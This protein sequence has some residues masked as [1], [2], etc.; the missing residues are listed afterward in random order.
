[1]EDRHKSKTQL[2]DELRH[3]RRQL[4]ERT[5]LGEPPDTRGHTYWDAQARYEA[6]VKAF[7]GLVYIC[8]RSY[9]IEYTNDRMIRRT[10]RNPTGEKCYRALHDSDQICSW[11]QNERVFQGETVRWE[12]LSPK[13]NHWYY[14]VNTPIR[15]SDGTVSKMGVILDITERKNAEEMLKHNEKMLEHILSS[16]PLGISYFQDNALKWANQAMADMFGY[17]DG[18]DYIGKKQIEF[19]ASEEEF[20]EIRKHISQGLKEGKPA[21]CEAMFKRADGSV[22]FGHMRM[23]RTDLP[24][25]AGGIICTILDVTENRLTHEAL[26]QASEELE[27]RVVE[28]TA[29]LAATNERLLR[30]IT[31]RERVEQELREAEAKYRSLVEKVPAITYVAALDEQSSTLYVSPQ[32]QDYLGVSPGDYRA[33]PDIWRKRI[34]PDDRDRVL[35]ALAQ[36][37]ATEDPFVCEYRMITVEDRVVWFHD[38]AVHVYDA[39]GSPMFLQGFMLDITDQKEAEKELRRSE[40]RFRTVIESARDFIFIKTTDLRYTNVNPA[41]T[42]LLGLPASQILGRRAEDLYGDD[43]GAHIN[44]VDRRVLGGDSIEEEHTRLCRGVSRTFHDIRVPLRSSEG[45]VTGICG[46]SRDITERRKSPPVS[47]IT[48]DDYPSHAMRATLERAQ[49][50]CA[51]DG[52]VL[53]LGESGTGKD[54]LAR[55]IHEH[56]ARANGPFFAINCA[57]LAQDLAES[58]LFGHEPGAFTGA[59]GRKR[60]LLEL[61]EGGTLLLNE[62]GELSPL[63]QSKLLTFLDSRS[64]LRVGGEKSVT[65]NARL[66]A[67][68]HRDLDAEVAQGKFL[69]PLFY[70]LNVFTIRVPPLRERTDDIPLLVEQLVSELAID[71]QLGTV[72]SV[73][74][75]SVNALSRYGWPGNVRELRNVLERA[76]MLNPDGRVDLAGSGRFT[77]SSGWSYTVHFP[78]DRTLHEVTR[79]TTQM[80]CAEAL[81]RS[82]GNRRE[83][84]R[85]LG[86]SRDSLYRYLKGGARTR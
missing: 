62:I 70:R 76:L 8:S 52:I 39:D 74:T 21:Q 24:D 36:S 32:V 86:I 38:E 15:R 7:E 13:D 85:L 23:S 12:V 34:H 46:I 25:G 4:A 6:I 49:H 20:R 5:P 35:A 17:D 47:R 22:F 67:A 43:A 60:G 55:W 44:K 3:L 61:A 33:D 19:F 18:S 72:P 77:H 50:A 10:G 37:H 80:L 51:T 69:Q 11:C 41:M 45:T 56:S 29:E 59:R 9:D 83:A 31:Q 48:V 73:D 53:M 1:M 84:A 57:A 27:Q 79:E 64:F 78:D 66:V 28:R 40:E 75:S 65:V 26:R 82:G 81:R 2:I 71:M 68:T 16:S 30:E 54:Y 42:A 58:E 14:A 63:L